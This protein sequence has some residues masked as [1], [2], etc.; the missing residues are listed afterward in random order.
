MAAA[1]REISALQALADRT[2]LLLVRWHLLRRQASAAA[3]TGNFH[4]WRRLAAQAADVAHL[5]KTESA[6]V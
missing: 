5:A 6:K 1:Q 2:G 4:G 3:L